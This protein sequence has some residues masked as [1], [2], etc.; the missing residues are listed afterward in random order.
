MMTKMAGGDDHEDDK[1]DEDEDVK[2]PQT[3]SRS[4]RW[5]DQAR[6]VSQHMIDQAHQA[7]QPH[8]A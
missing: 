3:R 6:W 7:H 1:D 4:H 5:D 8:V 2:R